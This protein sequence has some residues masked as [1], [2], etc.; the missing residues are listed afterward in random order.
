MVVGASLLGIAG[1]GDDG[2]SGESTDTFVADVN[3]VCKEHSD[4][5]AAAASEL[6]AGGQLPKPSEFQAL[7][8]ETIIPEYQAEVTELEALTPPEDTADAYDAWV[9][10]SKD[11]LSQMMQDPQII[12][13]SASFTDVN[14]EAD[15]LGF[16][17][18]CHVGP[19]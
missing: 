14:A 16:S 12:T 15:Q 11:T 2:G 6:L 19:S 13:D 9:A 1:C 8:E 18:D 10:S 7:A 3:A 17:A 4:T 5:I